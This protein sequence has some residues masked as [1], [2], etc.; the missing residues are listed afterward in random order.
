M[1]AFV[2]SLVFSFPHTYLYMSKPASE[3]SSN[4]KYRDCD[5]RPLLTGRN[6]SKASRNHFVHASYYPICQTFIIISLYVKMLV[7]RRITTR[8][9]PEIRKLDTTGYG[10]RCERS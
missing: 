3:S 2:S 7:I 6:V 9:V 8:V 5:R 1:S 4:L 10:T